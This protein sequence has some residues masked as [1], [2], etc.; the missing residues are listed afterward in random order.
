MGGGGG[1]VFEARGALRDG[2]GSLWNLQALLRSPKV[3]SRALDAVLPDVRVAQAGLPQ[4]C[5][6]LTAHLAPEYE[7]DPALDELCEFVATGA[8]EVHD[9]I[10]R[11]EQT[12]VDPRSRLAL[13]RVID[14][15]TPDLDAARGLYDLLLGS[16]GEAAQEV[17]LPGVIEEA[18]SPSSSRGH[19]RAAVTVDVARRPAASVLARP[20]VGIGLVLLAI[21]SVR[22]AGVATPHVRLAGGGRAVTVDALAGPGDHVLVAAPRIVAPSAG[23]ARLAA[24]RSGFDLDLGSP[25]R[26]GFPA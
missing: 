2:V 17:E 26:V 15:R 3:A 7:R 5:L 8:R 22:T 6:V 16:V 11:A 9:A 23:V 18:L 13:E 1:G 14:A 10:A 24:R 25:A 21:A 12:R 20:S 4:A 19:E